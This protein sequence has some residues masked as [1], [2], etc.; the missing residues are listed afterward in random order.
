MTLTVHCCFVPSDKPTLVLVHG[1]GAS[2]DQWSGMF[3]ELSGRYRVFAL[4]LL[5]FGHA[6]KPQASMI[7]SWF[8]LSGDTR[9]PVKAPGGLT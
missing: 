7:E 8:L 5:G 1:F 6:E 2:C 3:E 9:V 4:D